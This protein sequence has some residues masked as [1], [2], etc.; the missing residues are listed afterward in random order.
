MAAGIIVGSTI[1]ISVVPKKNHTCKC[2]KHSAGKILKG[3]GNVIDS[4]QSFM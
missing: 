4:L 3:A 2:M 1:A